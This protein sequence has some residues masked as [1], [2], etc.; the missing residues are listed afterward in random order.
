MIKN[1]VVCNLC[2]FIRYYNSGVG[3]TNLKNSHKCSKDIRAYCSK[4]NVNFTERERESVLNAQTFHICSGILPF[5]QTEDEGLIELLSLFVKLGAIHGNFDPKLILGG[6]K[7]VSVNTTDIVKDVQTKYKCHLNSL[8]NLNS[9]CLTTDAWSD[10]VNKNSFIDFTFNTIDSG[11]MFKSFQ[12]SMVHFPES[13]TASNLDSITQTILAEIGIKPSD[14]KIITDSA[15]NN[16]K[17]FKEYSHFKCLCHRLNTAI[18]KGYNKTVDDNVLFASMDSNSTILIG[19]V[20]RANKQNLLPI[21]LKSGSATRPWRRY[22]HKFSSIQ[23]SY[24]ALKEISPVFIIF[25]FLI[26]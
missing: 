10:S 19:N 4:E 18:E 16:L 20:N 9:I 5:R 22:C 13:K 11:F 25:Y 2:N 12:Y 7:D 17:A 3:T 8:K 26:F 23:R 6:R 24:N 14:I 21:K 15:A 1:Y